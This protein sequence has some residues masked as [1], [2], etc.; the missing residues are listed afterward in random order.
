VK[1]AWRVQW[2]GGNA[3]TFAVMTMPAV[4]LIHSGGLS[5]RQWRGLA[6][7]LAPHYRVLAP[8]LL[9]YGDSGPWPAGE[10]FHFHQDVA[11]LESLLAGE[12]EPVHV[13]GHSY[14]GLL[15]LHL[16][17]KRPDLVRSIAVYEPV[18]FSVL[19]RPTDAEVRA[20]LDDVQWE[21]TAGP[22]E[23]D[24]EWLRGFVD[25][26]S[27]PGAW[28]RLGAPTKDGFRSAGWKLYQEV[29]SLAADATPVSAYATINV[30]ALLLAGETSPP[31][32]HRIVERLGAAL[33]RA[34]V[35]IIPGA[36]HMGP[37]S[38]MPVFNRAIAEHLQKA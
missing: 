2:E 34:I 36:G 7:A 29:T 17:L 23:V 32:E 11:F 4:L 26:W 28:D 3:I 10:P 1:V 15:T 5:S 24:E 37:I 25:W 13:V 35:H 9:G 31:V 14:G 16:A 6:D 18:A 19:D 22:N 12:T 38:H 20:A 21:W 33:P 30:P 27:G 8:D